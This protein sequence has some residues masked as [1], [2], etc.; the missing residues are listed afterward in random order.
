MATLKQHGRKNV[1]VETKVSYTGEQRVQ[2]ALKLLNV[3]LF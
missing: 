2:D 1:E 3:L